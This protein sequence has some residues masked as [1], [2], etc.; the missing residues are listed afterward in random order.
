MFKSYFQKD[1]NFFNIRIFFLLTL[2]LMSV[3]LIDTSFIKLYDIITRNVL[4]TK[5]KEVIFAA[6]IS[7]SILFAAFL[8]KIRK[9]GVDGTSFGS[10]NSFQVI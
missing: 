9:Q 3:I 1:S 2:F 4:S 8:F 7:F 10:E 5:I 6:L